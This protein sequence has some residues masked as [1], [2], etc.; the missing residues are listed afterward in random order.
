MPNIS[1]RF[2]RL[3]ETDV[4]QSIATA[5]GG[6]VYRIG[7]GEISTVM[8]KITIEVCCYISAS[9]TLKLL[10]YTI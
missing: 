3:T 9:A 6:E 7:I 5:T 2:K 8:E 10:S 4:Y 1:G